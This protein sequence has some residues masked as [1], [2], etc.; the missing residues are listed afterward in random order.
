MSIPEG[1]QK[2]AMAFATAANEAGVATKDETL[3]GRIQTLTQEIM[4]CA[5][6]QQNPAASCSTIL[7]KASQVLDISNYDLDDNSRTEVNEKLATLSKLA[8]S[9]ILGKMLEEKTNSAWLSD[10]FELTGQVQTELLNNPQISQRLSNIIEELGPNYQVIPEAGVN[11]LVRIA[12]D[13]N[14]DVRK[15]AIDLLKHKD[16]DINQATNNGSTALHGAA[17]NGDENLV[18]LLLSIGADPLQGNKEGKIPFDLA[19]P[20]KC[21]ALFLKYVPFEST[22]NGEPFANRAFSWLSNQM[23]LPD[24]LDVTPFAEYL[25]THTNKNILPIMLENWNPEVIV[26]LTHHGYLMDGLSEERFN[27]LCFSCITFNDIDALKTILQSGRIPFDN[28]YGTDFFSAIETH[29]TPAN[30]LEKEIREAKNLLG[31]EALEAYQSLMK[32]MIVGGGDARRAI[33]MDIID[34][35]FQIL[36]KNEVPGSKKAKADFDASDFNLTQRENLATARKIFNQTESVENKVRT[37]V[38][39]GKVVLSI[40]KQ[41]AWQVK[42]DELLTEIERNLSSYGRCVSDQFGEEVHAMNKIVVNIA[43]DHMYFPGKETYH[44][45]AAYWVAPYFAHALQSTQSK[46]RENIDPNLSKAV[47]PAQSILKQCYTELLQQSRWN[48]HTGVRLLLEMDV[49][50]NR[51]L[52]SKELVDTINSLPK[53]QS[54]LIPV[55]SPGHATLIRIENTGEGKVRLLFYNTGQGLEIHPKLEDSGTYQTFIEYKGVPIENLQDTEDWTNLIERELDDMTKVYALIN[56]ICTGG[57]K[58]PPSPHKEYYEAVQKSGSCAYQCFLA[59]IRERLVT[60][61]PNP[62]EGLGLYKIVKGLM[63]NAF[64]ERTRALRNDIVNAILQIKLKVVDAELGVANALADEDK[65]V[66]LLKELSTELRAQN[67][68]PLA[69]EIESSHKASSLVLFTIVRKAIKALTALDA[70]LTQNGLAKEAIM[71][72]REKEASNEREYIETLNTYLKDQTPERN[73]EWIKAF[74]AQYFDGTFQ[75]AV[76]DWAVNKL[77]KVPEGPDDKNPGAVLLYSFAKAINQQDVENRAGFISPL[78]QS[79]QKAG[80]NEMVAYLQTTCLTTEK[81]TSSSDL[82]Y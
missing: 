18:G 29:C 74:A 35:L 66:K 5:N 52:Q 72:R 49:K 31:N 60:S 75:N 37:A 47:D 77:N 81:Q 53:G 80:N 34:G 63:L 32:N 22:T 61:F 9:V 25:K 7:Q 54:C 67:L 16:V 24:S 70:P 65:R 43:L 30:I 50:S 55:T 23:F 58:Q 6:D 48:E 21:R 73:K 41:M 17:N 4:H 46:L 71:A 10:F 79:F 78:I 42:D 26:K 82:K 38:D 15:F 8:I 62:A 20:A 13:P 27:R 39:Q 76:I 44:G 28:V 40:L 3:S 36:I 12:Y 1:L 2:V 45:G 51:L 64:E 59:M 69:E 33:K 56:K 57:V 68:E 14:P 19:S 11:L